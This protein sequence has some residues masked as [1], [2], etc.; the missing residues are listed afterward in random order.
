MTK[1]TIKKC[2]GFYPTVWTAPLSTLDSLGPG[3]DPNDIAQ[4]R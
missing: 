1:K 2:V 3:Y 4:D